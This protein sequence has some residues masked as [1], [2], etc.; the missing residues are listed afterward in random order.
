MMFLMP[1]T[2]PIHGLDDVK[3]EQSDKSEDQ[4]W[5]RWKRDPHMCSNASI[6]NR[7]DFL[8]S[9]AWI[10]SFFDTYVIWVGINAQYIRCYLVH[11]LIVGM[12]GLLLSLPETKQPIATYTFNIHQIRFHS[13]GFRAFPFFWIWNLE[14]RN[15]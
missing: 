14:S 15:R 13:L 12:R 3:E 6:K 7:I 11:K 4:E 9:A 5:C 10:I 1:W 8:I 2:M